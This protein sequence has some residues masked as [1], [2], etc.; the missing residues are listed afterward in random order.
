MQAKVVQLGRKVFQFTAD[1]P[2]VLEQVL[3]AA[4]IQVDPAYMDVRVNGRP[5]GLD[6]LVQ[7]S[8][9]VTVVPAIKGGA[10]GGR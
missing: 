1:G 7:D 10:T 4:G 5:A 2:T 8:D 3:A 9:V 6:Q